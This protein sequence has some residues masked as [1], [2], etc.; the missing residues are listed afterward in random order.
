M[1]IASW[2]NV[3]HHDF[4]WSVVHAI[5]LGLRLRFLT[6]RKQQTIITDPVK[7]GQF[8][9]LLDRYLWEVAL[10][11]S[12][13][14]DQVTSSTEI[15]QHFENT[16]STSVH[17]YLRV[18][19][20]VDLHKASAVSVSR[21]RPFPLQVEILQSETTRALE[22]LND[23]TS[24]WIFPRSTP[25]PQN[26]PMWESATNLLVA[27]G[28]A[29]AVNAAEIRARVERA[30]LLASYGTDEDRETVKK[31]LTDIHQSLLRNMACICAYK[32]AIITDLQTDHDRFSAIAT[33][34]APVLDQIQYKY[35]VVEDAVKEVA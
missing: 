22:E 19:A 20:Q 3:L 1:E 31:H 34:L 23:P 27:Y 10:P 35:Y 11:V 33:T 26:L 2:Q 29:L 13:I 15:T 5:A 18:L 9:D 7:G 28:A 21:P 25:R 4:S 8:V 16:F 12:S 6:Y 14:V 30:K 17:E 24:P 32:A